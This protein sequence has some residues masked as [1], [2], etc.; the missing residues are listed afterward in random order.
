MQSILGADFLCS[1]GLA[2]K[3]L[4]HTRLFDLAD[5]IKSKRKYEVYSNNALL[6]SSVGE[7]YLKEMDAMISRAQLI[8]S[9]VY[10]H[11]CNASDD[12]EVYAQEIAEDLFLKLIPLGTCVEPVSIDE[13]GCDIRFSKLASPTFLPENKD[14]LSDNIKNSRYYNA[15]EEQRKDLENT[16]HALCVGFTPKDIIDPVRLCV[17]DSGHIEEYLTACMLYPWVTQSF[18]QLQLLITTLARKDIERIWSYY[19]SNN[20]FCGRGLQHTSQFAF[21]IH[22]DFMAYAS[23]LSVLGYKSMSRQCWTPFFGFN[24]SQ[25]L[26]KLPDTIREEID[27]SVNQSYKLYVEI[28]KTGLAY[29]AQYATLAGFRGRFYVDTDIENVLRAFNPMK[30]DSPLAISGDECL[31]KMETALTIALPI[32]KNIM[33]N[34]NGHNGDSPENRVKES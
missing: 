12:G 8:A 30:T 7:H 6:K 25:G 21:D 34:E 15:L 16:A 1:N 14:A 28:L 26:S 29:E 3:P 19:R 9:E 22:T 4:L 32:I 5:K 33:E 20:L 23:M 27:K 2:G 24:F 11:T 18:D 17:K 31:T 13:Q 10:E